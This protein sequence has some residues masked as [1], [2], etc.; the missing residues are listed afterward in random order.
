[1]IFE[2]Q[3]IQCTLSDKGIAN[4]CFNNQNESV[5]KFDRATL[6]EWRQVIELLKDNKD[7]KAVIASSGKP[8]FIVG[9]DITEFNETI[10]NVFDFEK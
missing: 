6:N 10:G 9:A 8:V 5:N 4:M 2:G 7:V 3:S 1:M